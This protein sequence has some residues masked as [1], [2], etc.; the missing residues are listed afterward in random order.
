MEISRLLMKSEM[1]LLGDYMR[2]TESRGNFLFQ[3]HFPFQT[4]GYVSIALIIQQ[5][6]EMDFI[7]KAIAVLSL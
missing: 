5:H 7:A 2:W 6:N 3:F 4:S 1:K